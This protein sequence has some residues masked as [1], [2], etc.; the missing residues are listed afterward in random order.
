[1]KSWKTTVCGAVAAVGAYLATQHDPAWLAQVGQYLAMFATAA[2]G[3][4]ARD[5]SVSSERAG[6]K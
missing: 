2:M 4:F 1:M 5:N 3:F 6:I